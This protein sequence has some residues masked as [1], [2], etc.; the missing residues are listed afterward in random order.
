[1][2]AV[3]AGVVPPLVGLLA[4]EAQS[5]EQRLAAPD[6]AGL[7]ACGVRQAGVWSRTPWRRELH[8]QV[9]QRLAVLAVAERGLQ[10]WVLLAGAY[11]LDW[12]VVH[13]KLRGV[14]QLGGRRDSQAQL[15]AVAALQLPRHLLVVPAE[16]LRVAAVPA[17][18]VPPLVGLLADEAQSLEQRLAAPD[19]AARARASGAV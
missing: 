10:L 17:G 16:A 9:V 12:Y 13:P 2:A 4:D 8:S 14:S 11:L 1:V 18:V 15:R 19:G 7:V 3:P 6:G 5:L